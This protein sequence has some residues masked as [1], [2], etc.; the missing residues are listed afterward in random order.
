MATLR[1]EFGRR[2]EALPCA[3]PVWGSD[4]RP[5]DGS[6]G[7]VAKCR[8]GFVGAGGVAARHART[9]AG[10]PQVRLV[11]VTDLDD[12]RAHRFAHEYGVRAVPDVGA[13]LETGLDAVF[14]CVPPFA[15][16]PME[17]AIAAA[18]VALFVEK[19][20][21]LDCEVAERIAEAVATTRVVTA[22]G[23]HWRYSTAV[24]RAQRLL[25]GRQV[26]LATGVWLDKAPPVGWWSYRSC[27]GGQ[28]IEQAVHVLD[29]ARLLVGEVEEVYALGE[30]PPPDESGGDVDCATAVALRF[31]GGA[32]GTLAA[33]CRLTWKQ[34]AGLDLYADGLALALTENG[35]E[36]RDGGGALRIDVD[37]DEA[38]QASDRAFVHAVL[39]DGDE[40]RVPYHE[41]LRTHRLACAVA[42]SA[43][44]HGPVRLVEG[45]ADD[46][47]DPGAAEPDIPSGRPRQAAVG[48]GGYRHRRAFRRRRPDHRDGWSAGVAVG[49]DRAGIPGGTPHPA[50]LGGAAAGMAATFG[51]P[52]AAVFLPIELLVF[53]FST[54]AFV[55][56]VIASTIATGMHNLIVGVGP[57]F[58]VPRHDYTGLEKLPLFALLGLGCGLLAV[59]IVKGCSASSRGTRRFP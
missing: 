30:K 31:A 35:L 49:P 29:L 5:S 15:H 46:G 25:A 50:G 12:G 11:S 26:R 1:Q 2:T 48:G 3:G 44:Q 38:K 17:E 21:A 32:V 20:L 23:H 19:P 45:E 39:G 40:V 18:G 9:L 37:P 56:L 13:L 14:V 6:E 41:A 10:F 58:A 59:L 34:R 47:G 42:R 54:R 53:E 7:I 4:R 8:I 22:V 43:A 24:Q 36:V 51:T 27:S 33:T 55:P 16:G 57:L 28:I 52:I